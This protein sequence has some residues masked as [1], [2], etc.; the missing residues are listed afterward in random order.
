MKS[1]GRPDNT[2]RYVGQ[3]IKEIRQAKNLTQTD[4]ALAAGTTFQQIQKYE[5]GINRVS[6]GIL[7]KIANH[8]DTPIANFF[9]PQKVKN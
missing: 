5:N 9:P 7:F 1:K 8:F 4:V 6:A 3:K 2:D